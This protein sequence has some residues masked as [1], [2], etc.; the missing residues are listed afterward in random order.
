MSGATPQQ[1]E[2]DG[3]QQLPTS[4]FSAV[5]G[6]TWMR[7]PK[8]A[9]EVCLITDDGQA[10][11]HGAMVH[12][13]ALMTFA[14][15][16]LGVGASD[17]LDEPYMA[18]VQLQFQF[19]AAAP[20]RSMLTCRP[21]VVRKTSQLIFVRGLIQAGDRVVGSADA[22]FKVLGSEKLGAIKAKSE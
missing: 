22:M 3:W 19:T 11:D 7:G 14:D 18:T 21:E 20:L 9:R 2:A 4:R 5:I 1:L 17:T 10:N 13:G 15:I 8:G 6:P 12:G 16:A